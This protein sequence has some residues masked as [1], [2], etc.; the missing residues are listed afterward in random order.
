MWTKMDNFGP[1]SHLNLTC[2][3]TYWTKVLLGTKVWGTKVQGTKVRGS[4]V[5]LRT[6]LL[7][8]S[9]ISMN[10]R[11]GIK[12]PWNESPSAGKWDLKI[13]L[14]WETKLCIL[15]SIRGEQTNIIFGH[16]LEIS[17]IVRRLKRPKGWPSSSDPRTILALL[18]LAARARAPAALLAP[19]RCSAVLP[20][21]R[22]LQ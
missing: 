14:F 20:L 12:S 18:P 15:Q 22:R 17:A 3:R 10:I 19:R 7:L 6:K 21:P 4:K 11:L 5:P 9:N 1:S 13:A 16:K 8:G 2:P